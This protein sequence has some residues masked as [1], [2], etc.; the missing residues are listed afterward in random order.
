MARR[1]FVLAVDD[2]TDTRELFAECLAH[3]GFG[4]LVAS[5]GNDAC[6]KA[7]TVLPDVVLMDL[8]MPIV[9]G[10]EAIARIKGHPLTKDAVVFAVTGCV[11]PSEHQRALDL[12]C[13]KVFVKPVDLSALMAAIR[14][15]TRVLPS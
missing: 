4:A 1:C 8:A 12:G 3:H 7:F 2:D 6:D 9:D 15:A 11:N 10:C 13:S 5:D 14:D